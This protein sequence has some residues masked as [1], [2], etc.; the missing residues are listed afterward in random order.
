M[1]I[2]SI[3]NSFSGDMQTYVHQIA[4]AVGKD[5]T[6]VNAFVGGCS[7]QMHVE[8]YQNDLP[9]YTMQKN[10]KTVA[11]GLLLREFLLSDTFD[12]VTV[13]S[14]TKGWQETGHL[15]TAIPWLEKLLEI[16]ALYQKKA[17]V[18]T[19]TSWS[20]G[21][22]SARPVFT[23]LF[24]GDREA[25]VKARMEQTREL[26]EDCGMKRMIPSGEA[27]HLAYETFGTRMH[28]DGAHCSELGRYLQACLWLE[29]FTGIPA[30]EDFVPAGFSYA[31]NAAPA[32]TEEERRALREY[33]RRA[34]AA[35]PYPF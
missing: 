8:Q 9:C 4:E 25:M 10:G 18:V 31:E 32:P 5:F 19:L 33:A 14:G 1:K 30:P 22:N 23:E 16:I 27:L 3:G 2:L 26:I 24:G 12:V 13:H 21:E 29:Y 28:R 11:R 35:N 20:D 34:L 15:P 6:V 17:T 7:M